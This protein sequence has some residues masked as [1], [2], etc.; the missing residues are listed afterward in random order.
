[1]GT[2]ASNTEMESALPAG[3]GKRAGR[4][5]TGTGK[6]FDPNTQYILNAH[7][8]I[9]SPLDLNGAFSAVLDSKVHGSEMASNGSPTRRWWHVARNL[10]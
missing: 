9:H 4:D 7:I 3:D 6:Q 5:E 8:P 10:R 1:M 2:K